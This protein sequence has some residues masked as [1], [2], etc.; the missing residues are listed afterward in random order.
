MRVGA[1]V[2]RGLLF[3][4]LLAATLVIGG[5]AYAANEPTLAF[6]PSSNAIDD[7]NN[8]YSTVVGTAVVMTAM[9]GGT[10]WTHSGNPTGV[11]GSTLSISSLKVSDQGTYN[12]GGGGGNATLKVY[13][14]VAFSPNPATKT[15]ASGQDVVFTAA[16]DTNTGITGALYNGKW[17]VNRNDGN[18]WVDVTYGSSGSSTFT[19]VSAG[20]PITLTIPAASVNGGDQYR[21]YAQDNQQAPVNRGF[22]QGYSYSATLIVQAPPT[23]TTQPKD[24]SVTPGGSNVSMTVAFTP[25]A[26]YN[27]NNYTFQWFRKDYPNQGADEMLTDALVSYDGYKAS[28]TK[29]KTL[30]FT[31]PFDDKAYM[32]YGGTYYCVIT[33]KNYPTLTATSTTAKVKVNIAATPTSN[34]TITIPQGGAATFKIAACGGNL[35][36][37]GAVNSATVLTYTWQRYSGSTWADIAD[38]GA[39]IN[40]DDRKTFVTNVINDAPGTILRYRCKIS[41]NESPK[42]VG[43]TAEFQVTVTDSLTVSP[44]SIEWNSLNITNNLSYQYIQ[45]GTQLKFIATAQSRIVGTPTWSWSLYRATSATD[46]NPV[47]LSSTPFS[48]N[49]TPG[50][51]STSVATFNY[52]LDA[53]ADLGQHYYFL[54]V[55]DGS[56]N[57]AD[58][59]RTPR[60]GAPPILK[61]TVKT[62]PAA[63]PDIVIAAG[64]SLTLSA[65]RNGG[66]G[67]ERIYWFEQPASAGSPI[68]LG[69]SDSMTKQ[70]VGA[71]DYGATFYCQVEA[72][73][74]TFIGGQVEVGGPPYYAESLPSAQLKVG[75]AASITPAESYVEVHIDEDDLSLSTLTAVLPVVVN[76]AGGTGNYDYTWT[77]TPKSTSVAGNKP[78]PSHPD[79]TGTTQPYDSYTPANDDYQL[80]GLSDW[81]T[82]LSEA[83]PV[84]G[85]EFTVTC[86]VKDATSGETVTVNAKIYLVASLSAMVLDA[87]PNKTIYRG[88]TSDFS[89]TGVSGTQRYTKFEWSIQFGGTTY[90]VKNGESISIG[91]GT[92]TAVAAGDPDYPPSDQLKITGTGSMALGDYL[93]TCDVTDS[94]NGAPATSNQMKLTVKDATGI[95]LKVTIAASPGST[96]K[97]GTD[98]T[99]TSTTTGG[100]DDPANWTYT[101]YIKAPGGDWVEAGVT[102]SSQPLLSVPLTYDGYQG[103]C[104]VYDSVAMK[105]AE[106]E[107]IT[108]H[109]TNQTTPPVNPPGGGDGGGGDT[110][111]PG[112]HITDGVWMYFRDKEPYIVGTNTDVY[113]VDYKTSD[114]LHPKW[115]TT[116][117]DIA[118]VSDDGRVIFKKAGN[119]GITGT[120]TRRNFTFSGSIQITVYNPDDPNAFA[121][122]LPE[123]LLTGNVLELWVKERLGIQITV[124]SA[125]GGS[126][127]FSATELPP[128]LSMTTDGLLQG[129]VAEGSEGEY[130]VVITVTRAGA[131]SIAPITKTLNLK[132]R[133]ISEDTPKS[134]GSGGGC[135]TGLGILGMLLIPALLPKK[136]DS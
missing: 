93:I 10:T 126:F 78:I 88:E 30:T 96:V 134:G 13:N 51:I 37:T 14:Q 50:T 82:L 125:S 53:A 121:I 115:S 131:G 23:I 66:T 114:D 129:V 26:G 72:L 127:H 103:Y 68:N 91:G 42:N 130:D 111:T 38:P 31:V 56:G 27:A 132:I 97:P 60:I 4:C 136:R 28:G 17:Q 7:G 20:A 9:D 65:V 102:G 47:L 79:V 69:Q 104:Q 41:D 61:P 120:L 85:I 62:D 57:T 122:H 24:V 123:G 94:S 48:V 76:A 110:G 75:I 84:K 86:V 101:W 55:S 11:T 77:L 35:P 19:D 112:V 21:V 116:S 124:N 100:S 25:P 54:R 107:I 92:F 108:L 117:A 135:S 133:V 58:T 22:F 99:I 63:N 5:S 39:W 83:D 73:N 119:V 98:V 89:V 70:N 18:G 12:S 32:L 80:Y 44:M 105:N 43:Y 8:S 3:L 128:G 106:S 118:T 34:Y 95:P 52:T 87:S 109:V 15:F 33:D 36:P 67:Q 45:V 40:N 6:T 81:Q 1:K 59:S 29:T 113:M 71:A 46:Q 16:I 2:L 64:G 49:N 74:D 90:H